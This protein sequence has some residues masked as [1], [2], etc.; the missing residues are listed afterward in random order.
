[1]DLRPMTPRDLAGL[2]PLIVESEADGFRFL[3]RI[4][5]EVAADADYLDSARTVVFG[6]FDGPRLIAVGGLTP[7]PYVEDDTVGRV[8]HVY[9]ARAWRRQGVGRLLLQALTTRARSIYVRLRLRADT[10]A[11]GVFYEALEFQPIAEDQATH[12]LT[13]GGGVAESGDLVRW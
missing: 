4:P 13:L 12:A 9:V 8:R 1:M 3:H 7:D 2:D 5:R 11:A 10:A 6:V